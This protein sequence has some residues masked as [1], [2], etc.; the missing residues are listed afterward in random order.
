MLS[1]Y[2]CRVIASVA[3]QSLPWLCARS[4]IASSLVL[5]AMTAFADL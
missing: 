5:L 2:V 1:Y 4:E 3:K